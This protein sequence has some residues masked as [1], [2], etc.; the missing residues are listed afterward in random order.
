MKQGFFV[1]K[2]KRKASNTDENTPN[3]FNFYAGL[4]KIQL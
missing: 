3:V 1:T 2:E 4:Y